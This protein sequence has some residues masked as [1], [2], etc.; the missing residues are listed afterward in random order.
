MH[1]DELDSIL[2]IEITIM[3]MNAPWKINKDGLAWANQGSSFSMVEE[4]HL[5]FQ[6]YLDILIRIAS[7]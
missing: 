4:S 1:I 5:I 6:G 3:I 7:T 2:K